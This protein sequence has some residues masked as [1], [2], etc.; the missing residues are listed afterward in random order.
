[1][2]MAS[3]PVIHQCINV[4]ILSHKKIVNIK[5]CSSNM[6]SFVSE[7]IN[8]PYDTLYTKLQAATS[9]SIFADVNNCLP[10]MFFSK[11]TKIRRLLKNW[12]AR[13][14]YWAHFRLTKPGLNQDL[15]LIYFPPKNKTA[16]CF[17][18][19]M[20]CTRCKVIVCTLYSAVSSL[21]VWDFATDQSTTPVH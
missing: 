3:P 17:L 18:T 11:S 19:V 10:R 16:Y 12:K 2:Q 8:H 21:W 5:K 6:L 4:V 20:P 7:R 13:S 1:M 9:R 14:L 15:L